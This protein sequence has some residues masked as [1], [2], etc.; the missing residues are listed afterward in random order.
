MCLWK[1]IFYYESLAK[2]IGSYNLSRIWWTRL[3]YEAPCLPGRRRTCGPSPSSWRA[4]PWRGPSC[5]PWALPRLPG[6]T[7]PSSGCSWGCVGPPV[8]RLSSRAAWVLPCCV[9]PPVLRVSSCAAWV[10][11][12]C[13]CPPVLR[14]LRQAHS[15]SRPRQE[16]GLVGTVPVVVGRL[17]RGLG[18]LL[19]PLAQGPVGWPTPVQ[20]LDGLFEGIVA[21]DAG[22]GSLL[23]DKGSWCPTGRPLLCSS[24]PG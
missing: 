7:A 20:V 15:S 18:T 11:P 19:E 3:W 24:R 13:V 5:R 8:L 10:L 17:G 21:P 23:A 4:A 6:R 22:S 1:H 16:G 14:V 9:C 12:S 2:I